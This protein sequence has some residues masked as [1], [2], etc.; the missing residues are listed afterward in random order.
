MI[1]TFR[2][3]QVLCSAAFFCLIHNTKKTLTK[4]LLQLRLDSIRLTSAQVV[5]II[6]KSYMRQ[7]CPSGLVIRHHRLIIN[8]TLSRLGLGSYLG[9]G[10]IEMAN[11][12][13]AEQCDFAVSGWCM[14]W[15]WAR[16]IGSDSDTS[17]FR[18]NNVITWWFKEQAK[19]THTEPFGSTVRPG[20]VA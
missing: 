19:H 2:K 1:D 6:F 15:D 13:R 17:S 18:Y 3:P 20:P 9:I 16:A 8:L 4:L 10:S 11:W 12:A 7:I 5:A 14:S